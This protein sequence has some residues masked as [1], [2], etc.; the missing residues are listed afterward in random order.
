MTE[1]SLMQPP[2]KEK[3]N[4]KKAPRTRAGLSKPLSP[5][6]AEFLFTGLSVSS[7]NMPVA[8]PLRGDHLR[9]RYILY[10]TN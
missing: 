10:I 4:L 5:I 1:S 9:T 2:K 7:T 8:P 6:A 3:K